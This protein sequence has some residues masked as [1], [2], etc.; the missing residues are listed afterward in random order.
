MKIEENLNENQLDPLFPLGTVDTKEYMDQLKSDFEKV[1]RLLSES[2]NAFRQMQHSS[3]YKKGSSP[4]YNEDIPSLM[5]KI[6]ICNIYLLQFYMM[7][8]LLIPSLIEEKIDEIKPLVLG[9]GS[10]IDALSL[11]YVLQEYKNKF[12]VNYTGIDIAAWPDSFRTSFET[13][14]VQGF[15]QN[16]WDN[17]KVFDGNIIF[18]A[19][20]LSELRE[21]PDDTEKFCHGLEKTPF[22]S[23]TVYLMVSYRT[24]ASYKR[25]WKLTDWQKTQKIIT[26]M[27]N[28]GYEA[29]SLPISLNGKWNTYLQMETAIADDDR[30]WP[31]YYVAS[32]YNEDGYI[33]LK[34]LAPDF[35]LPDYVGE[36][37]EDPGTIRKHCAYYQMRKEKYLKHHL[38]VNPD[39]VT[40]VEICTTECPI[41][42]KP[43]PRVYFSNTYSPCFQIIKFHRNK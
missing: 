7:Y 5:Y 27:E 2:P 38:D 17:C 20:V 21:F 34:D 24:T 16:Y 25:D 43:Y 28:K 6:R 8:H 33:T 22:T 15:L 41:T 23:E 35:A 14:F 3:Y 36:Y 13:H 37:L 10:L 26:A 12:T 9:C 18:F 11:S 31:C 4:D 32:P 1:D 19:T 30:V 29:K 40:P 42:C 39:E